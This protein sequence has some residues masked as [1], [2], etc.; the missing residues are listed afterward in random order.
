MIKR[1]YP[2]REP[3]ILI[4]AEGTETINHIRLNEHKRIIYSPKIV[5][6][7]DSDGY[8]VDH[9]PRPVYCYYEMNTIS[10]SA[11]L[12]QINRERRI[13]HHYYLIFTKKVSCDT[14]ISEDDFKLYVQEE[15]LLSLKVFKTTEKHIN[16]LFCSL[17][18][19]YEYKQNCYNSN[20]ALHFKKLLTERGFKLTNDDCFCGNRGKQL[21][22][23]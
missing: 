13:S 1:D 18:Y 11:M 16:E 20:S 6:G 22:R 10:P 9:L 3:I 21:K 2:N 15:N 5:Y 7:L 23:Y 4:I 8:G 12:Q 17:L 14:I 19:Y